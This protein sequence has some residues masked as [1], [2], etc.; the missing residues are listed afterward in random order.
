MTLSKDIMTEL[1]KEIPD[2]IYF[3]QSGERANRV[4]VNN[5]DEELKKI[6][7]ECYEIQI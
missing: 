6:W 7:S 5:I 3:F 1:N 4:N 2:E